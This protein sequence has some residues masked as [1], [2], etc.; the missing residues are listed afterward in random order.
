MLVATLSSLEAVM[1]IRTSA[2]Y[3]LFLLLF[4]CSIT[5]GIPIQMRPL[6]KAQWVREA[7]G[8]VKINTQELQRI[9]SLQKPET[10]KKSFLKQGKYSFELRAQGL[11]LSLQGRALLSDIE[12]KILEK[13]WILLSMTG[14][15]VLR[16]G[17]RGGFSLEGSGEKTFQLEALYPIRK[18]TNLW[19]A[20][21][22]LVSHPVGTAQFMAQRSF[23]TVQVSLLSPNPFKELDI[24]GIESF[25]LSGISGF[26]IR[27]QFR[28]EQT[29]SV[30]VVTPVNLKKSRKPLLFVKSQHQFDVRPKRAL[31]QLQAKIQISRNP[32]QDLKLKLPSSF[33][34]RKVETS[35]GIPFSWSQNG[36]LHFSR[37]VHGQV[38]LQ[39]HGEYRLKEESPQHFLL[40]S[41]PVTFEK[42]EEE[43]GHLMFFTRDVV[44]IEETSFKNT[45]IL[46]RVDAT[47]LPPEMTKNFQ[48]PILWAFRYFEPRLEFLLE[49]VS[50]EPYKLP[51]HR[52]ASFHGVARLNEDL[53]ASHSWTLEL[54][55]QEPLS[56]PL[57][58][59]KG[60]KL[61]SCYLN[62]REI[63]AYQDRQGVYSVEL[64]GSPTSTSFQGRRVKFTGTQ[65]GLS[66]LQS[67]KLQIHMESARPESPSSVR[68][69]VSLPE[70]AQGLQLRVELPRG[71]KKP[72][73]ES[74][75][76][77]SEE[78]QSTFWT[79]IEKSYQHLRSA[80][81]YLIPESFPKFMLLF[82]LL[83]LGL[84]TAF[85]FGWMG[86]FF[87]A[88]S[89]Y[90]R[91][92]SVLVLALLGSFIILF[93][94]VSSSSFAIR[95]S[96]MR[97]FEN[98]GV[99][100]PAESGT[101]KWNSPP[102]ASSLR[103]Q[104]PHGREG[105][106]FVELDFTSQL[107]PPSPSVAH[108]LV[109]CL[110]L[111]SG[112]LFRIRPL[113]GLAS[114]ALVVLGLSVSP[115]ENLQKLVLIYL[116][117]WFIGLVLL[118]ETMAWR[119]LWKLLSLALL[120]Q[121]S[122]SIEAIDVFRLDSKDGPL[123]F[124]HRAQY[125]PLL[126]STSTA[127]ESRVIRAKSIH[128]RFYQETHSLMAELTWTFP[129]P[130]ER[131]LH[132]EVPFTHQLLQE[133][134]DS[135]G[136]PLAH[137]FEKG[138]L[139]PAFKDSEEKEIKA[140]FLVSSPFPR[141]WDFNWRSLSIP[142]QSLEFPSLDGYSLKIK[143][144]SVQIPSEKGIR[145]FLSA[146]QFSGLVLRRSIRKTRELP[147]RA[148]QTEVLEKD[149]LKVLAK[150]DFF[151][152]ENFLS[153]KSVLGFQGKGRPVQETIL[154]LPVGIKIKNVSSHSKLADWFVDES[155]KSLLLR[156]ENPQRG[157]WTVTLEVEHPFE[158]KQGS[159][160][161]FYV[162]GVDEWEN[163]FSFHSD[164]NLSFKIRPNAEFLASLTGDIP[165][166]D[167]FSPVYRQV[168]KKGILPSGQLLKI[169]MIPRQVVHAVS[170][171]IDS[172]EITTF[173]DES[174]VSF[175]RY[176]F[177]V[178]NNGQ[179]FLKIRFA[180]Q[181]KII[182]AKINGSLASL[183]RSK[184]WV[185]VPM[186]MIFGPNRD[187]EPFL[188]ECTTRG[189]SKKTDIF[190]VLVP[191]V[192]LDIASVEYNFGTLTQWNKEGLE[193]VAGSDLSLESK[194]NALR[195]MGREHTALLPSIEKV[196][197]D[198]P[199]FRPR[200][201]VRFRGHFLKSGEERE[202]LKLE[203]LPE[204]KGLSSA[205]ISFLIG[206]LF[207]VLSLAFPTQVLRPRVLAPGLLCA[208]ILSQWVPAH[209]NPL[210]SAGFFL[211][212]WLVPLLLF[213]TSIRLRRDV[214]QN[215]GAQV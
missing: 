10:K 87:L 48:T 134:Q 101:G 109:F 21:V 44:R 46:N 142:L 196:P 13:G 85:E 38:E 180:D 106:Y 126:N 160:G 22:P 9:Q 7:K 116:P 156:Y 132:L 166:P 209:V 182:S 187:V 157:N 62:G 64:P 26:K 79:F 115:N 175:T 36:N 128:A 54:Q 56:F 81:S 74:N 88:S 149:S 73:I 122:S 145:A 80:A 1:K 3:S 120:F 118:F 17:K 155:G 140:T 66:S 193:L 103:F 173:L 143:G 102:R 75:F 124:M 170:A 205:W 57:P 123:F 12:L 214:G 41:A 70:T 177:Q 92:K 77:S 204:A 191:M 76:L 137:R 199:V 83:L 174:G 20:K 212:T 82:L 52:L 150:H 163:Q 61:L 172:L 99:F 129:I 37:P 40:S 43:R 94:Q 35:S 78:K 6:S 107:W 184:G 197:I 117:L 113:L 45:D 159:L 15:P 114:L 67:L 203:L 152:E 2:L 98:S 201:H 96:E 207:A 162:K 33:E 19:N 55:T 112:L 206:L 29:Q 93:Y 89:F 111:G 181:E 119:R 34:L 131:E 84:V 47:E 121:L 8:L 110:A 186:K 183:G 192:N 68:L 210:F 198:F 148:M 194:R 95:N 158:D 165:E 154:E 138:V 151:L 100:I 169:T 91:F 18:K 65:K 11:Y 127:K 185:L 200:T 189:R 215:L 125:L 213:R 5:V 202:A 63:N 195:F 161:S 39:V 71:L 108:L 24:Q 211:L 179:Q 144:D 208:A 72:L 178:R 97:A 50:F 141:D 32:I 53:S 60:Y 105:G 16:V 49:S 14:S 133:I 167:E 90:S 25:A 139:I 130:G 58:L 104:A 176:R 31:Y 51:T 190:S 42:V 146:G 135:S 28:L 69:P 171:F 23:Q 4:L 147:T 168:L 30:E 59:P 136:N 153:G 27:A 188:F 164:E 86:Q